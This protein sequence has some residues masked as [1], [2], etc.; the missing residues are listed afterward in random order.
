MQV[1]Q[2]E[3]NK[4]PQAKQYKERTSVHIGSGG[5]PGVQQRGQNFK[6]RLVETGTPLHTADK[7]S[8]GIDK[9]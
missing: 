6:A 3:R 1:A 8:T 4:L 9:A 7:Y 2:L 5:V